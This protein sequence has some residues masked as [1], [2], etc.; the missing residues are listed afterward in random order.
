MVSDRSFLSFSISFFN[1]S[2]R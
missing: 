2:P 1:V